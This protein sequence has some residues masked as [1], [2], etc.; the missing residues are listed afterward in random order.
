LTSNKDNPLSHLEQALRSE[1]A[2]AVREETADG[3]SVPAARMARIE[4]L[5]KLLQLA[6][7]SK[8][9]PV[10]KRWPLV[11]VAVATLVL[12]SLLLFTHV[13][14]T[15]IEL[16]VTV[17]QAD[18]NLPASQALTRTLT[19][20]TLGMSGLRQ[21][22]APGL[23]AGDAIDL[24]SVAQVI[25]PTTTA[26]LVTDPSQEHRAAITLAPLVYSQ[27]TRLRVQSIG[28]DDALRISWAAR[29][30]TI[31]ADLSG[32]V[33]L[34]LDAGVV[35]R[36]VLS[37]PRPL[38]LYADGETVDL[39]LRPDKPDRSMFED[40]L[41]ATGLSFSRVDQS[42]DPVNTILRRVS[43][44]KSG[45]LYLESL[46]GQERQVR[47][48]E[49]LEF[50][51]SSG[52]IRSLRLTDAGLVLRFRGTVSGMRTG[53]GDAQRSL[54]PSLLEWLKAQ[55]GLSLL[56]GAALYV[57]GISVSLMKWLGFDP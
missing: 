2:T 53:W 25:T 24:T 47:D 15:E 56:W 50:D 51:E 21:A 41:Q 38:L 57:L 6:S 3:G 40:Q 13:P 7:S 10:R 4:R 48:G 43:S 5:A 45:T 54:M 9:Q 49:L 27:D 32:A 28:E 46:G 18:F 35:Q 31:Q 37:S 19:T 22:R 1:I 12:L 20:S 29:S 36:Y 52:I 8:A 42:L 44:I 17:D 39:D 34:S 26:H 16:E 23:Q 55:H 30:Q 33:K 11:V 14:S